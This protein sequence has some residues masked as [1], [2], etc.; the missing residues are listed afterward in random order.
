MRG[1]ETRAACLEQAQDPTTTEIELAR[2]GRGGDG[3]A[4][5]GRSARG[6][7]GARLLVFLCFPAAATSGVEEEQLRPDAGMENLRVPL[8][9]P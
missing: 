9:P 3:A 8:L 6:P 2:A 7:G 1:K 5:G 4:G